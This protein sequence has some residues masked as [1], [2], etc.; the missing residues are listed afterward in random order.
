MCRPIV[1]AALVCTACG[2]SDPTTGPT[3]AS[4]VAAIVFES[5]TPCH[6]PDGPTPFSLQN[7][8]DVYK[9]RRQILRVTQDR[10]MPPWLPTHGDFRDDRG[11]TTTERDTL[12]RWIE[13]GAPQ[14]DASAEPPCP[15][16]RSGWQLRQPDLVVQ[17]VDT[18]EITADGPDIIRN[19]VIPSPV[20][21]VRYVEAIELRPGSPAVH[22]AVLLADATDGSRRL[23]AT[24]PEPGFSGMD[25]ATAVP[26]DGHFLGW[27]PGK[28][29]RVCPEGMAWRLQPGHDLVLQ[30]HLAP[31]G[32]SDRVRPKLGLYF[33]DI[34][35][36]AVNYPLTLFSEQIDIAPGDAD[37]VARDAFTL[38][39]DAV[40]HSI[41]PHAHYL[42]RSMVVR[43]TPPGGSATEILR[44]DRWDFDWQD[45]YA[46]RQPIRLAAGTAIDFEYRFD[47]SSD[48]PNNP[49][50]PPRRVRSGNE[51]T[52]EM[53]TLGLQLTT[54]DLDAR[55]VLGEALVRHDLAKLGFNASRMVELATLLRETGRPAEGIG[56]LQQVRVREPE[57]V[58]ALLALAACQQAQGLLDEAERSYRECLARDP[59]H[60]IASV[61]LGN[62]LVASNRASDA[63]TLY[64]RQLPHHGGSAPLHTNLATAYLAIG[65]LDLAEQFYRTALAID[66]EMFP[67]WLNLGR[68]LAH[69][70]RSSEARSAFERALA[71]RPGNPRVLQL[72]QQLGL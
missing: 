53:A 38:P 4:D 60:F 11:L 34:A 72:V 40:A 31:Y 50:D 67:A 65:Q 49:F 16:F 3:F 9:R 47:N 63:I 52:D 70:K 10:I 28:Q 46:F 48:N 56:L 57:N 64:R 71:I 18:I 59:A 14:G 8:H 13:A 42:A 45:D 24:D 30:V 33:T 21:R 25:T 32:K 39:V 15:E 19:V 55:R 37:F 41:Y 36:R 58:H 2:S 61:Q 54:V 7:Y 23:D 6:R 5:C 17:P 22:H 69:T 62:L 1:A 68:V 35:P 20:D 27:T 66:D 29:P 44:I 51:S 12:R 43:I 26:P